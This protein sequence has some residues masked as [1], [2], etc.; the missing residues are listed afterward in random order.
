MPVDLRRRG[1]AQDHT[2]DGLD[3]DLAGRPPHNISV[4]GWRI[5]QGL[6]WAADGKALFAAAWASKNPPVLR[7][8]L[9]GEVKVVHEGL[10]HVTN[11][12][13]SPDGRSLAFGENTMD[14][15]LWVVRNLH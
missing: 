1:K 7:I 3:K 10:L 4:P 2:V 5:V 13:P 6:A 14:S 15:N 9:T 12:V 8:S 11:P